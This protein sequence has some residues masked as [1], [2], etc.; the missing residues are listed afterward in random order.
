M[1]CSTVERSIAA[2]S[3][4]AIVLPSASRRRRIARAWSCDTRD[5]LTPISCPICFIVTSP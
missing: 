3:A 2:A 5:S 4:G 1:N